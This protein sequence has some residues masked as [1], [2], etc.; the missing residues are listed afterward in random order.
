[1]STLREHERVRQ[2]VMQDRNS[3]VK[4]YTVAGVQVG[5]SGVGEKDR[6]LTFPV[7]LT[8]ADVL[9]MSHWIRFATGEELSE[10]PVGFT[11]SQQQWWRELEFRPKSLVHANGAIAHPE[12]LLGLYGTYLTALY[13]GLGGP[14]LE[15]N[16]CADVSAINTPPTPPP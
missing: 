3:R 15:A 8:V 6:R 12:D 7:Y 11:L 9:G 13:T 1:M 2:E 16:P 14:E 10:T 4:I 5:V